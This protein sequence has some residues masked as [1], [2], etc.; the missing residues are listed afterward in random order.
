MLLKKEPFEPSEVA[1]FLS[2]TEQVA[3]S[4]PRYAPRAALAESPVT[5]VISMPAEN[6]SRW[7]DDYRYN[8][9]PISD[10]SPFFWHFARFGS[11]L[12]NLG[13][14]LRETTKMDPED[15]M[16]ERVLLFLLAFSTGFAAL[17]LL[18]PFLLVRRTWAELPHK[19]RAGLYFALLGLGFMF[20]EITLIQKFTLFL[21]Y[22]T[23]SLTV[24]L[25]G[26]LVFTGLGSLASARY[27]GRRNGMLALLLIVLAALTVVYQFALGPVLSA[28]LATTLAVRVLVTTAFIAPLGLVVGAFMPLGLASVASSTR[29]GVVY[30][31]WAWAINGL[32]SV[33]GSILT[34]LLSMA[35]GFNLVLTL[36]IAS[37]ALAVASIRN[38][39]VARG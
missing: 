13:R 27:A 23:Y 10:D 16:G 39:P 7:F 8:V 30:V 24:T 32:F 22:P 5:Q 25:A 21:G 15:S 9:R 38:F 6:L 31:A 20:Y 37:Y 11:V 14:R 29:H 26:L 19:G 34:T 2:R 12:A 33:V 4:M 35:Y 17:L 3:G 28:A 1:R 36:A 18:T